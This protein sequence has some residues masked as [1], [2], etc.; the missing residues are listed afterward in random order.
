LNESQAGT[1]ADAVALVAALILTEKGEA[2][3][4]AGI[5]SNVPV[6]DASIVV[7]AVEDVGDASTFAEAGTVGADLVEARKD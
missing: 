6:G 1:L 4:D 7:A 3:G 5:A 2:V